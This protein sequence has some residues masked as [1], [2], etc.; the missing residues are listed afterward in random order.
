MG[1]KYNI[2]LFFTR[3]MN[4]VIGFEGGLPWNSVHQS[5]FFKDRLQNHA[6]LMGRKTWDSFPES[7]RPL[8]GFRNYILSRTLYIPGPAA[9]CLDSVESALSVAQSRG[10]LFVIGG[11]ETLEQFL[12]HARIIHRVTIPI[13]VKKLAELVYEP[14]I[15]FSEWNRLTLT[16]KTDKETDLSV[17]SETFVR[18]EPVQQPREVEKLEGETT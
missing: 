5:R 6:V 18:K 3:S 10:K 11:R 9:T 1:K 16:R 17:V 13:Q 8:K 7:D 4:G 2:E 12:P 14:E 15:D